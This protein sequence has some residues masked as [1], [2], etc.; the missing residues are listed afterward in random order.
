MAAGNN[1]IITLGTSYDLNDRKFGTVNYSDRGQQ[2][3]D[4]K[5]KQHWS[6][7][8]TPGYLLEPS[9][10]LYGKLAYH[11]AK[12]DYSDSVS[13]SGTRNHH[14]IGYGMGISYALNQN[15]ELGFEVQHVS[16]SRESAQLSDGKPSFT[17]AMLRLGY[18]F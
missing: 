18:R 9:L 11:A 4:V 3:V 6:L 14:G 17:E 15:I 1:W 8:V 12:A 7:F 13:G 2:T 5:L 16:L 10:M